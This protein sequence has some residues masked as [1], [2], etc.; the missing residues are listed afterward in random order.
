MANSTVYVQKHGILAGYVSPTANFEGYDGKA[1]TMVHLALMSATVQRTRQVTQ[2]PDISVQLM[3]YI[4]DG[5]AALELP[6]APAEAIFEEFMKSAEEVYGAERFVLHALKCLPSDRMFI[7]LNEV[8]YGGAHEVSATKA[9]LRIASEPKQEHDSLPDRIMTLSSGAQ[10]A[11]QAGLPNVVA[12]LFCYFLVALELTTWVRHPNEMIAASP[13]AVALMIASPA[14]YYGLAVPSPRGFDKTGKGASI[15]EG[16]AAMQ[17]FALAYP[18]AKRVVVKRL[19]TP[20]PARSA[21]AILRNPTGTSGLSVLRTNRVSAA[22]A[23]VAPSIAVNPVARMVMRPL[24]T[25]DAEAYA[26]ALFGN[27]TTVSATAIQMA[28]KACPLSNA[29]A[30]LAKFR[31]SKTVAS[32]IGRGKMREIMRLQRDDARRAF[33]IAFAAM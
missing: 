24:A 20:L 16:I 21:V 3:T 2:N 27:T 9:A 11:V 23:E 31:S 15:S 10:G 5:A 33:S 32:F 19:R 8:Y 12:G 25:F 13:V 26:T 30:W 7:F 14:A 18:A 1:M 29:E 6:T 22:L 17:S 4:D 28:W